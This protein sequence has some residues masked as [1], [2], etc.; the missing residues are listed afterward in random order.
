MAEPTYE[1]WQLTDLT[2]HPKQAELFGDL[3]DEELQALVA[4]IEKE[5][6]RHDIEIL[7]DGT[8]VRGHQRTRALLELGVVEEEVLVRHDLQEEGELA[9]EEA[10][11]TDNLDRRQLDQLDV[12]RCV[13]RLFEI[14]QGRDSGELDGEQQEALR[15][16]V[17]RRIGFGGRNV[18]R[19]LRV[20]KTPP[21]V[22]EAFRKRLLKLD[23]AGKFTAVHPDDK[24]ELAA[25][26]E[27][28]LGSDEPPRELRKA[29]TELVKSYL[30][31]RGHKDPTR[32]ARSSINKVVRLYKELRA[33]KE[34]VHWK[35]LDDRVPELKEVQ[36]FLH[37]TI[38]KIEAK[39][40]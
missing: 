30:P 16:R 10:L 15:E 14:E 34:G 4:S 2:P 12:A 24:P 31:S 19:Y 6:L 1:T 22:Q 8:I 36:G 20:L 9:T 35:S 37:G 3:P 27:E 17:G 18:G 5:G 38:K 29:A 21:V 28:L 25:E 13:E 39:S 40:S 23:L 32:A 11:I 26:L 7:P 33:N